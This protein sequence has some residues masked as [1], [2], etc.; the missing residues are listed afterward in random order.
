MR[1]DQAA[2]YLLF[3]WARVGLED[4]LTLILIFHRNAHPTVFPVCIDDCERWR[5]PHLF[6]G[7][8]KCRTPGVCVRECAAHLPARE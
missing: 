8:H 3:T 5:K 4:I 1:P 2:K 6:S 7:I